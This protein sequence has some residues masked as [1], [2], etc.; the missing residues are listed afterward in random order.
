[1]M[2]DLDDLRRKLTL[3]QTI[4]HKV[5]VE[6]IISFFQINLEKCYPTV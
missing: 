1:M 3:L 5:P 2:N 6:T 4:F